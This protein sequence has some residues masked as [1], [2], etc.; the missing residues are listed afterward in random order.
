M[1]SWWASIPRRSL[2]STLGRLCHECG[3]GER[4]GQLAL[5]PRIVSS[6]EHANGPKSRCSSRERVGQR[7]AQYQVHKRGPPRQSHGVQ[8]GRGWIHNASALAWQRTEGTGSA[9]KKPLADSGCDWGRR[10]ASSWVFRSRRA[11]LAVIPAGPSWRRFRHAR[12]PAICGDNR[13]Q[14]V[15]T[16]QNVCQKRTTRKYIGWGNYARS[17]AHGI[18]CA[19]DVRASVPHIVA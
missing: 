18:R 1:S 5:L 19:A 8:T 10:G 13:A 7:Q 16:G 4:P 11:L 6:I 2:D 17:R 12:F 3:R 9:G 14:P 15:V